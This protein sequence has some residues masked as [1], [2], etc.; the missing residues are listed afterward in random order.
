MGS[1]LV[2]Q[3]ITFGTVKTKQ[4]IKDSAKVH[5]GQPGFPMADRITGALPP[6]IMATDI[7]LAGL[8]GRAFG[9]HSAM[10]TVRAQQVVGLRGVVVQPRHVVY[11]AASN[12]VFKI[13]AEHVGLIEQLSIDEAF[14]EPEAL[15]GA[16]GSMK[17]SSMASCSRRP[18]C[19]A[20]SLNTLF[21]AAE[22]TT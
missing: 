17:A 4:A 16:P 22:Y 15:V 8:I 3:V 9:A 7:P 6:A 2:A 21:D 14:M 19:S 12:K 20:R 10:P 1:M 5:F 18:T 13:L 11:S